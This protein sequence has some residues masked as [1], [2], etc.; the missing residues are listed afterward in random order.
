[1]GHVMISKSESQDDLPQVLIHGRDLDS[2]GGGGVGKS[3]SAKQ[4]EV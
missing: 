4:S 3:C 1:V 2:Q